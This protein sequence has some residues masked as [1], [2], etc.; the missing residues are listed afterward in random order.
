ML[1][2]WDYFEIIGGFVLMIVCIG[3]NLAGAYLRSYR[4]SY[5][6]SAERILMCWLVITLVFCFFFI[7]EEV[8]PMVVETAFIT[9]LKGLI[10]GQLS[11]F[12]FAL[13]VRRR[14]IGQRLICLEPQPWFTVTY[15]KEAVILASIQLILFA[16]W[17][18]T[19]VR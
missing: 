11:V 7:R 15:E 18:F 12:V 9:P 14:I 1:Q 10:F 19:I 17:I 3:G 13:A 6:E 5:F 2:F 8:N 16:Y 4:E